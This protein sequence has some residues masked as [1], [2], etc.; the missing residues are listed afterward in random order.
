MTR[1]THEVTAAVA[2][3]AC[4]VA[5]LVLVRILITFRPRRS[6][7]RLIR[8]RSGA[9]ERA[10]IKT[11]PRSLPADAGI[12]NFGISGVGV[13]GVGISDVGIS[14][15]GI[16]G[17]LRTL[18][19]DDDEAD[20]DGPP[21][22][23]T[24]P[25]EVA[26]SHTIRPGHPRSSRRAWLW[27]EHGLTGEVLLTGLRVSVGRGAESDVVLRDPTVSREHAALAYANGAW[28]LLPAVTSNGTWVNG[29]LVQPGESRVLSDGDQL[30][31]GLET[32]ARMFIPAATAE[33][34]LVFAAAARTTPGDRLKKNDDAHLATPQLLVVADGVSDRPS[35]HIASR[36][37]VREVAHSPA[38]A[39]I[40]EVVDRVN[41]SVLG[42][43]RNALQL[44]GMATTLDFVRLS[45]DGSRGWCLEG[46]HV[47]DGQVLLQDNL[48]IHS[49]T[50]EDTVGGRLASVDPDRAAQLTSDPDFH[51]LTSAVGLARE[52]QA[53]TW[54]AYAS[55]EQRLV[56]TTDGLVRALGGE[57]LRE[58]L[59]HN[60]GSSPDD[61][62]DLLIQ[63][64]IDAR[65]ADNVTV[66]VA[67]IAI[68]DA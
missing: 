4:A 16:D 56:L 44:S 54:W 36:T 13:S 53:E 3:L 55:R 35:P 60:R 68:P 18:D 15:A 12:S 11:P 1:L 21:E 64:A 25:N 31:F 40:L 61:V 27:G 48:G 20:G 52:V 49:M 29:A 19:L 67:D 63:L 6:P 65:A 7:V 66:I 2:V 9:M 58:V 41:D 51:L 39:P 45:R 28:W 50:Q 46:A 23:T 10:G 14:D 34:D 22:V 57:H 24:L 62:A 17:A 32:R 59:R 42:I 30:Q 43:G 8:V 38:G 47:G 26:S 5:V 33:P 37:A